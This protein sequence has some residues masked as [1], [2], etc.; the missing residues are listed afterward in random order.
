MSATAEALLDQ[1]RKLPPLERQELLQEL[2][3]LS[4]P[5]PSQEALPAIRVGGGTITSEQVADALDDE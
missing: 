1:F 2:L 5:A 3:R 4:P